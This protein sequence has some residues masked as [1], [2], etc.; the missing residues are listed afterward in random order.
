MDVIN[1][2]MSTN[3]L[4]EVFSCKHAALESLSQK[5]DSKVEN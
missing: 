4:N 2:D 1:I 3:F 5:I